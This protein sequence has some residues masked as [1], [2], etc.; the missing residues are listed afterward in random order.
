MTVNYVLPCLRCI[1][2]AL[3]P[4]TW[5]CIAC[6]GCGV[7]VITGKV[8]ITIAVHI[9]EGVMFAKLRKC[10]R[11]S[12]R[13]CCNHWRNLTTY[14]KNIPWTLLLTCLSLSGVVMLLRRLWIVCQS[15][16]VLSLVR[17]QFPLKNSHSCSLRLWRHGMACLSGSYV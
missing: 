4:A 3:W 1:M 8:C 11:R 6:R 10:P 9:F 2:T 15:T 16:C 12:C 5:G 17:V 7:S 13:G 14:L